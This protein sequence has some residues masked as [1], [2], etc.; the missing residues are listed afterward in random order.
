MD[1]RD[2]ESIARELALEMAALP[3]I[4]SH[5]HLPSE[6]EAVRK[7]ADVLTRLYC[8]YSITSA[9]TA[10]LP[11]DRLALK[12]TSIPLPERWARFRPYLD[13]I[14]DT[15]HA[16]AAQLTARHLF[17]VDDINDDTYIDLSEKLQA[18]NRPGSYKRILGGCC[19]IERVLN[20]G[21]W[22]DGPQGWAVQVYRGFMGLAGG[23]HSAWTSWRAEHDAPTG[24][25]EWVTLWL[26][27]LLARGVVGLKFAASL[28]LEC[29]E[30]T[31]AERLFKKLAQ[32]E[33][34]LTEGCQL[35]AWIMHEAIRQAPAFRLPVAVHCGII[36]NNWGDFRTLD[37]LR[38][39]P[40][41]QKHRN[42]QFDLYHGGI[43]WMREIAV[44]ANQYPN[45]WLNLVWCHQIS[46]Y[47]TESMLN[48]WMDLVPANKIIGFAGDNCDGPEKTFG[49]LMMARENIARAL[50]VRVLRG[51]MNE[52]RALE[53]TRLWF[54]QNPRT[55]YSLDER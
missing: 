2:Q 33:I 46:P 29:V 16:R 15:G 10:G 17:D 5:E 31:E 23:V 35:G 1:R 51:Q 22:D 38:L 12:D 48:E 20:Q 54:H 53:I 8:H 42:T 39:I 47:M 52:E 13:A 9:V 50:A 44:M 14:R 30:N 32:E 49:V 21:A 3:V 37:P 26:E 27:R 11:G 45:V 55:L 41:I 24:P 25:R 40:L 19:G 7:Q 4:D 6:E 36:W 18:G 28:P 34:E 43:P